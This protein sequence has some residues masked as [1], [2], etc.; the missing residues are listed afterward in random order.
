[1]I[2]IAKKQRLAR[3]SAKQLI[4]FDNVIIDTDFGGAISFRHS[5]MDDIDGGK[6]R[7]TDQ[8]FRSPEEVEMTSFDK[9]ESNHKSEMSQPDSGPETSKLGT[10]LRNKINARASGVP[11]SIGT[12]FNREGSSKQVL[13]DGLGRNINM[14]VIDDDD[15]E[16]K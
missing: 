3:Q 13:D 8:G 5:V 2:L 16:N 1:M 9:E 11:N 10:R 15:D 4:D 7:K 6:K 12:R 14:Y